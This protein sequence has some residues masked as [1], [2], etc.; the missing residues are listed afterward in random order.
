MVSW[1]KA[2]MYLHLLSCKG[3]S[4]TYVC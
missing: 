1:S 2:R 4:E 3:T